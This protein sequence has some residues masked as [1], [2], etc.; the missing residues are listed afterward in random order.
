VPEQNKKLEEVRKI[1]TA[2]IDEK[3]PEGVGFVIVYVDIEKQQQSS[4]HN[5]DS[6]ETAARI[7]MGEALH[8]ASH[9]PD[10][11]YDRNTKD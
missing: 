1:L 9:A 10:V 7:L 2:F 6:E 8:V 4:V 3:F 11:L 5:V